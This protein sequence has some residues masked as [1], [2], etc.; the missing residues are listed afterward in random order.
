MS[1]RLRVILLS[2]LA[3]LVVAGLAIAHGRELT[4][5]P[6]QPARLGTPASSADMLKWIDVPGTLQVETVNS[7]E[8]VVARSG[9]IN[10]DNPKA[11]AAGLVDGD[12][13]IQIYFHAITHPTKGLY[14]VD[15]GVE[16]AMRDAP[17]KAVLRGFLAE[18]ALRLKEMKFHQPLGDWLAARGARLEGVFLTHLHGDHISGLRDVP[19]DAQLYNGPGEARE[20]NA[21]NLATGPMTDDEFEGKAPLSEWGFKPDPS[22][23][24]VAVIDVFGDQQLWAISVPGHTVGSTAYL[25]RTPSGPV[26]F[27]GDTC[28]TAWGWNNDVEPGSFTA[29]RAR[30]ADSLH[31]LKELVKEHPNISVRLGH[32]TL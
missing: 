12:E 28:H 29:D 22:G 6:I 15:T 11:K 27:T 3:V 19:A 18:K 32:Q 20:R 23:R 1:S 4:S 2:V 5:H 31:R 21:M 13:P 10:L 17:D 9:L 25:A 30:N 26:L 7:T 8:W 16:R 24:F 14:I